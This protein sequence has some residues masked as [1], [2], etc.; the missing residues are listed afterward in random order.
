MCSLEGSDRLVS[1]V[2]A[3]HVTNLD[4]NSRT[5]ALIWFN[6]VSCGHFGNESK[7]G[8]HSVSQPFQ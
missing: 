3:A 7:M 5:L 2:P 1:W 4:L 6:P 8:N